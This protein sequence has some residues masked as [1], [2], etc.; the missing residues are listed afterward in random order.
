MPTQELDLVPHHTLEIL[1]QET[2]EMIDRV[3]TALATRRT[4]GAPF[5]SLTRNHVILFANAD[6]QRALHTVGHPN[7]SGGGRRKRKWQEL[8]APEG[9]I[10]TDGIET[11]ERLGLRE[12]G[13]GARAPRNRKANPLTAHHVAQRNDARP[14][15][16]TTTASS[17]TPSSPRA[18][19]T[20]ARKSAVGV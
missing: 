6:E 4:F 8:V 1:T 9:A 3:N 13:F 18:N 20:A 17:S 12:P 16:I 19:D 5:G 10:A 2:A 15:R 14:E 7:R 11:G